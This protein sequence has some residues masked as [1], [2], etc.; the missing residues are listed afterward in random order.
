MRINKTP[1]KQEGKNF[2]LVLFI[3]SAVV[4]NCNVLTRLVG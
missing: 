2:P 4:A 3:K 1:M